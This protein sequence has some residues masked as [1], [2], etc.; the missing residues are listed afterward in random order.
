MREGDIL[1]RDDLA[2]TFAALAVGGARLFYDGAWT[3]VLASEIQQNGGIVT[4]ED[5]RSYK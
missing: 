4:A 2:R 3:E 1:V 5:I